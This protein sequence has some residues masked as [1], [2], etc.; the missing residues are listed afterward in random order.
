LTGHDTRKL[1]EREDQLDAQV[2]PGTAGHVVHDDRKVD[3]RG[4]RREVGQ[5]PERFGL[6]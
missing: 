1:G 5:H 2:L 4:D 3:G 6:L